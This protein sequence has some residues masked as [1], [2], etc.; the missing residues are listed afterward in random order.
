MHNG[1][2][3]NVTLSLV[4]VGFNIK[5]FAVV[6]RACHIQYLIYVQEIK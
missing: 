3:T 6:I 2:E 1:M 5:D 4:K